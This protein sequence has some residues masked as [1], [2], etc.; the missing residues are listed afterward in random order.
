MPFPIISTNCGVHAFIFKYPPV[1]HANISISSWDNV[2][3]GTIRSVALSD[4]R[5]FMLRVGMLGTNFE[6]RCF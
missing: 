5:R 1:F 3:F 2:E 6:A 4:E